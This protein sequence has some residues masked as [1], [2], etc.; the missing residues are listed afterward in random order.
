MVKRQAKSAGFLHAVLTIK[1]RRDGSGVMGR[2]NNIGSATACPSEI[3]KRGSYWRKYAVRPQA[4]GD[5]PKKLIGPGRP[6]PNTA[7]PRKFRVQR[8]AVGM[9]VSQLVWRTSSLNH[10]ENAWT[11]MMPVPLAGTSSQYP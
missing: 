7:R 5:E 6:F 3:Q 4:N 11:S 1:A 10:V 2:S 8:S 9:E